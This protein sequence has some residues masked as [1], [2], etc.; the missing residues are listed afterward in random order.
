MVTQVLHEH[1]R[2]ARL[3]LMEKNGDK[4]TVKTIGKR[5]KWIMKEFTDEA[6]AFLSFCLMTG[7]AVKSGEGAEV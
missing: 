5:R 6:E 2:G 3:V 1:R 4:Y 7:G